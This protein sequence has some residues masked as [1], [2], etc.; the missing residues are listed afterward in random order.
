MSL[1][2]GLGARIGPIRFPVELTCL[3]GLALT[4]PLVEAPKNLFCV[5]FCLVWLFNRLRTHSFGGPWR[6]WDTLIGLWLASGFVVAAGAA[7]HHN[8]WEGA[9]DLV[10]YGLP[11]WCL[12]RAGYQRANYL[13]VFG[14]LIA[15]TLIGLAWGY[16][17]VASGRRYW[18]E[19]N[20]VGHV[21]HSAIYLAIMLGATLGL[22]IAYWRTMR[23]T[24]R[25]ACL[26]S[27]VIMTGSLIIMA[28]RGAFGAAVIMVL[29]ITAGW[30]PRSRSAAIM[31]A[32]TTVLIAA[33][34]LLS[35]SPVMQKNSD[36]IRLAGVLSNRDKIWRT[37]WEE[38]RR[39]PVFGVGM[40]NYSLIDAPHFDAE[41]QARGEHFDPDQ[42]QFYPHA[43]NLLLNTLTERGLVGT[44]P[45]TAVLMAWAYSLWRR[46]P[47]PRSAALGC[48]TWAAA[49]SA[50]A[51]T[52][53]AGMANT[54]LH[55]EHGILCAILLGLWLDQ[56]RPE[57]SAAPIRE[58]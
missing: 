1:V 5:L 6:G 11:L 15:S 44:L 41:S 14:A 4:L 51:V 2:S 16:A 55:H 7:I 27:V 9:F 40:D 32:L 53:V 25:A 26:I 35:H 19:L 42:I 39:H 34:T 48:A 49:L 38:W 13:L 18:L 45:L 28:S 3:I 21:N 10:R 56:S 58:T 43:H 20:S 57:H 52:L 50:L 17:D 24:V 33:G 22:C 54:T 31:L 23:Q 8:E 46:R 12:S 29:L 47:Q 37:A 36:S 30:L